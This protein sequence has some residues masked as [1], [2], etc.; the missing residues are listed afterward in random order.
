MTAQPARL[1]TATAKTLTAVAFGTVLGT[2]GLLAG[3]IGASASDIETGDASSIVGTSLWVVLYVT[4]ASILGLG[5]GMVARNSTAAIAGLLAW[6]LVV[7][8]LL[9]A[10]VDPRFSRFLPFVAGNKLLPLG[11]NTASIETLDAAL[12]RTQ[13][14]LVFGG[15]A[16]IA[17]TIGTMLL[18][19]RDT[20]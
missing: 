8:N 18:C 16:A 5:I 13:D 20:N 19:R 1:V 14:A 11:D 12:T 9:N 6:W 10:F 3:L 15:Y 17:L 4:L 2:A 7:E